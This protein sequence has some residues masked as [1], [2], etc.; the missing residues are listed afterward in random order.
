[1]GA[2]HIYLFPIG[3]SLGEQIHH[4]F[5]VFVLGCES[6]TLQQDNMGKEPLF[7]FDSEIMKMYK[8]NHT[9]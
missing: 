6:N 7:N 3:P 2:A 1:M 8:S 9:N 5:E 4:W